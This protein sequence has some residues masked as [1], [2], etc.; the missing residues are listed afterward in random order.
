VTKASLPQGFSARHGVNAVFAAGLIGLLAAVCWVPHLPN[1]LW[2]DETLTY[3][4][5]RDGLA[6]TLDRTLH[7]QPQPAYSIFMWF[8]TRLAGFS[9][10]A[11]RIPSLIAALAACF[12]LVQLGTRLTRD[13]ETGLIAAIVFASSWNVFREAVDARSYTL[14][15]LVLLCLALALIRWIE[16]G[17][18][19]DACLC[20]VLGAI[21]PHLH[22]FFVLCYPALAVYAALRYADTRIIVKQVAVVGLLLL[23]GA[24]FF[25][26]VASMLAEN[27]SSYSFVAP[28]NWPALFQVFV[29]GGPVAGL[30]IGVALAGILGPRVEASDTGQADDAAGIPRDSAILVATWMLVPLLVLFSI[31]KWTEAS[32]FLGRYQIPAIPA[33]CLLYA[34]ALRGITSGPARVVAVVVVAIS[35]FASHE[36]PHD[37]FRGAAKAV[38][39]FVAG[40]ASTP[41][42]FA[43]GLVEAEDERWLRDPVLADYLSAP[44]EYYPLEG[45]VISIPRR[46]H[47]HSMSSEI[48]DPILAQAD[49]FVAIEWFGNGA[50]VMPWLTQRAA[51]RGYQID[52]KGFGG[53]R[54]AFFDRPRTGRRN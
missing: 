54:V 34:I 21:L 40:D 47:A 2:L 7:F 9:E 4:V 15:L 19:R 38:N 27:G 49:R 39:G 23:V 42:L 33:V 12:F 17:R 28:P 48:I 44:K 6:E 24:V 31:S 13:R 35:A 18:W 50:K 45:H 32:V 22:V 43:S 46:L 37:D 52:R 1:S 8:W 29:W 51:A 36:R 14:G 26:P 16:A 53:V 41:I 20:G 30:L 11:L 3:W 5:V 10:I 25:L